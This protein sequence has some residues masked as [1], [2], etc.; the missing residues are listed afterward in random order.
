MNMYLHEL[1]SYSKSTI[2]WT[3]SL[4]SIMG[5]FLIFFPSI[6][7]DA[8]DF[9]KLLE[10]YPE[11]I[12][13]ALG[14]TVGSI[15]SILGYYS[16]VFLYVGLCG[17]IQAMNIGTS[18]LSKEVRAKTADFL[19][20]KPVTRINII[21]SKILAAVTLSVI[22]NVVYI[23]FSFLIVS[24]VAIEDFSYKIFFMVSITLIFL[25]LIFLALGFIVSVIIPKIRS[26]IPIS[27][28]SVFI[29]FI[30]SM[31]GS[32]KNDDVIRYIT[33][34]QYFKPAY[35]INNASY[36]TSYIIVAIMFTIL[37]IAISYVVYLK[38]DIHAV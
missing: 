14:L 25:Q 7:N 17:A 38:K 8:D 11:E 15:T 20:T 24:I 16:Y 35:I 5:F 32:S 34:F 31:I 10:S 28:S 1:K 3:I 27:L 12:K 30:I 37:A 26:V 21:T 13:N 18:M 19:L 2:V 6:A 22:T 9:N 4:V 36:E 29:F 33:P 23:A